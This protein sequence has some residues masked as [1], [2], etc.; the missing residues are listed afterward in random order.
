[1]KR[2]LSIRFVALAALEATAQS[3]GAQEPD[4]VAA[5][6]IPL[7]RLEGITVTVSRSRDEINRLPYAVGLLGATQVQGLQAAISLEESL[8]E[9]PG[10]FVANRHNFALGDQISVRGFGARTQFG[11]RGIRIIQDG[12]PLTL[13][14]GQ[15]QLGNLDLAAAGRIEVIRGPASALYGNAAGG[16]ISVTTER[17]PRVPFHPELWALGGA[18]GDGRTYHKYDLK[19]AGRPGKLDYYGHIGLFQTDGFRLHS[20]AEHGLGNT[21]VRYRPDDRT[22]LTAVINYAHTPVAENPSSL[23]D[24]LARS[25]PD[26]ARDLALAPHQCPPD[27]GF[28]GCQNLREA[29]K[30]GQAGLHYRRLIGDAHEV[31][32][33]GYGLFRE[34]ENQIPFTFIELDRRAAGARAVYQLAPVASWFSELTAGLDIDQQRD[35]RVERE[36][37]G[38]TLGQLE[39]DQDEKV[40]AFGLFGQGRWSL[41]PMLELALSARYDLVRFDVDDRLVTGDN[42]D[43]SGTNTMRQL[44]PMAGLTYTHASWLNTYAS[45]GRSFLTPTTTELTDSLGGFNEDLRPERATNYELGL[46]GTAADRVSYSLAFF[47]TDVVDMIVG[48]AAPGSERVYFDNAGSSDLNGIEAAVSSLLA[49]GLTLTAAYTYSDLRF[50][51]F[52]TDQGDFSGNSLPG[53]PP[54]Q[55]NG[56]MSYLH[57]SG[58]SG[59]ANLRAVSSYYVDNANQSRNDGFVSIDLR[60]GYNARV[61]G[62]E[63]I[64]FLGLNNIFDVRYNSS[65]V[66]NAIAGR[67]YEPAPGRNLYLGLRLRPR[68]TVDSG[69]I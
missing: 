8:V 12:I 38:E 66:V 42:P 63:L 29:Y 5:D 43:D 25:N 23:S 11:V 60:L 53:V 30:Q 56:R 33:M 21:R 69:K 32:L 24:S 18:F 65:V 10:V 15:S 4:S 7:Y 2:F 37:D 48:T 45:V 47:H 64:P 6:S 14:D 36:S 3:A 16:V 19:L 35:D 54:H 58:L 49:P 28:G 34:L 68:R 22:E 67:Y 51:A 31:S 26:T 9:I 27:P 20:Q 46:K 17:A 13:P 50:R 1:M 41:T 59:W 62:L 61:R 57:T 52:A 55:Y 39:L 40:T 44:S